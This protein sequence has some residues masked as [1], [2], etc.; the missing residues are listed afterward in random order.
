MANPYQPGTNKQVPEHSI[1][2][3]F[4]KQTYLG[5]TFIYSI[6]SLELMSTAETPLMLITN[7]VVSSQAFPN[8]KS[9]F[10]GL[11]KLTCL[12][13]A[14]SVA[15]RIYANPTVTNVGTPQTPLN[16]RP[17]S[18]NTSIA[19]LS[20]SPTVTSNGT[21]VAILGS[22][23]VAPDVSDVLT[24]LDPGQSIL[25]TVQASASSTYVACEMSWYEI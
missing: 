8:N 19:A 10:Q 3:Y 16:L 15:F 1:L 18:P 24:I 22:A 4:N 23:N 6:G 14:N 20:T 2:D 25:V 5:N 12:T 13:A 17:A 21:L 11:K 9:I 7:P